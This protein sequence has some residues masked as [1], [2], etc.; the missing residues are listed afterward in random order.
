MIY[1]D[2]TDLEQNAVEL[3]DMI[4][5]EDSRTAHDIISQIHWA[6]QTLDPYELREI[7]QFLAV[8]KRMLLTSALYHESTE[9]KRQALR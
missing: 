2:T 7:D 3:A 5:F 8:L 1:D 6:L 9:R 4:D